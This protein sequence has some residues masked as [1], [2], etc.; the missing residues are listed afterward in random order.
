MTGDDVEESRG[1]RDGR[2][3]RTDLVERAREGD[4]PVARDEAV[5][6][7]HADDAAE[8]GRLA[9]RAPGVRAERE[10]H[11]ARRH[12][13]GAP[14]GRA[15][16]HAARV[17]GVAGRTERGVL[18]RGPHGEL[19]EIRLAD[20]HRAR[21]D[22]GTHHRRVVRRQPALEDPRPGRCRDPPGAQVV[23]QGDRHAGER[24]RVTA[25][26][27]RGVDPVGRGEGRVGG[28]RVEAVELAL[29][30][31]D[32]SERSLGDLAGAHLARAHRPGGR[33]RADGDI[34]RR[35]AHGASPRIG[36]TRNRPA[37]ASGA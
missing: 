35:A 18:G 27:H 9:D 26:R 14:P 25:C 31:L 20:D 7:L 36:G 11:E 32:A 1:V 21:G 10:R 28:H 34:P 16:R 13:G 5:G 22:D 37:S 15:P 30:G 24:A 4:E 17:P 33:E 6:R 12:R 8:R 2:R 23:L 19:V 3:E 29:E